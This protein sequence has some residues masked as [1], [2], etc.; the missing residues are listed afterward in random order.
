MNFPFQ[1]SV[2][3]GTNMH[4]QALYKSQMIGFSS[5]LKYGMIPPLLL[6]VI[7]STL[8]AARQSEHSSSVT[9]SNLLFNVQGINDLAWSHCGRYLAT[10]SD[11][12]TLRLWSS[13]TG[14]CLRCLEGHTNYV[15]SCCFNPQD[16]MLV[17]FPLSLKIFQDLGMARKLYDVLLL[18]GCCFFPHSFDKAASGTKHCTACLRLTLQIP[19]CLAQCK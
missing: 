7:A 15:Y 3:Y 9:L 11:D 17:R 5:E 2:Y 8:P 1:A 16:N 18:A 19:A 4:F 10:A 12:M 6:I 14:K 13:E